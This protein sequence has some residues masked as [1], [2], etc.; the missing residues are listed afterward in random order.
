VWV[1]DGFKELA[2]VRQVAEHPR[3][4]TTIDVTDMQ[5]KKLDASVFELPKGYQVMQGGPGGPPHGMPPGAKMPPGMKMPPGSQ[6]PAD[7]GG[8]D[9]KDK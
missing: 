9:T 2:F 7:K 1:P 5:Q 3:G 8:D 4:K 6:A